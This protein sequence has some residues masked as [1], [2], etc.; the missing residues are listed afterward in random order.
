[1]NLSAFAPV[2]LV[3]VV[4]VGTDAVLFLPRSTFPT[5]A[6]SSDDPDLTDPIFRDDDR[7]WLLGT[8]YYNPDDPLLLV[9][10]RNG[11]GW[12]PNAG[13]PLGKLLII[14]LELVFL[15]LALLRA[16]AH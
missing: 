4:L 9:P 15:L 1:M 6:G 12:T 16:L 5:E 2:L 11:R 3:G 14:G 8:I 13:H 7:Y 10:N